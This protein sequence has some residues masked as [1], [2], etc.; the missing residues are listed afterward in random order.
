MSP[1]HP[2]ALVDSSAEIA[3]GA[4]I[5]AYTVVGPECKV[6]SGVQ[7]QPFSRLVSHVTLG[8]N[9]SVHSGAVLGD[10]SQH[11]A[12]QEHPG[13]V[14]IGAGTVIREGVTVHRPFHEGGVTKIGEHC[15]LMANSH[16]AHDCS[17]GNKV[18]IVNGALLAGHVHVDDQVTLS[19]CV[20]IHQYCHIG[21]L[22][23]LSGGAEITCDVAPFCMVRGRNELIGLNIVG[24]R[25]AGHTA[26]ERRLLKQAFQ[27]A[28]AT[29]ESLPTAVQQARKALESGD[30][31]HRALADELLEF[32]DAEHPRGIVR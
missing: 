4:D 15:F 10:T 14:E 26:G 32:L 1:I 6:A 25:R 13:R 3:A 12:Y 27:H 5:Q 17:V 23:M 8:P 19:G 22:A 18:V 7:M 16:V 28:L 21:R 2:T 29:Q 24:L 30:T 20:L 31:D 11:Q 9:V